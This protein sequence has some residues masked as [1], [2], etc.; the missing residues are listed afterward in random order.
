MA[1]PANFF[2][3]RVWVCCG[4]PCY[5]SC[6]IP[7][8]G[9]LKDGDV[10]IGKMKAAVDSY[11]AKHNLSSEQMATFDIVSDNAIAIL[12]GKAKVAAIN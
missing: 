2:G 6:A 8:S 11:A 3:C 12:D 10:F 9:G 7:I 4:G 5:Q 1:S